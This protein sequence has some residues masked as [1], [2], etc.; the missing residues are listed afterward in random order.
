MPTKPTRASESERDRV[1][2]GGGHLM[3]CIRKKIIIH[4]R[5]GHKVTELL[6]A[7][8]CEDDDCR[9]IRAEEVVSNQYPCV[10]HNCPYYGRF[11]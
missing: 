3:M 11:G 9:A 4:H 1:C 5:C 7:A 6:L 10:V 2:G 8:P